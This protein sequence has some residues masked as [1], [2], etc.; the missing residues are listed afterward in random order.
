[1]GK[2]KSA[3]VSF[4]R[5]DEVVARRLIEELRR[6]N[7]AVSDAEGDLKAGADWQKA[8]EH[9]IRAADAVIVLVGRNA[10]PTKYQELEWSTIL[11]SYWDD[12][13]KLLVPV[14][15]GDAKVPSFLAGFQFIRISDENG[16]WGA[17]IA[18]LQD[19]ATE[20]KRSVQKDMTQLQERLKS[21]ENFA[22][23]LKKD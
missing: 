9:A 22:H 16:D 2:V 23:S 14:L 13:T 10:A 8:L 12:P 18:A 1:M 6:H 15:V 3:F 7:F 5:R 19:R 11:E 4:A 17:V 20:E 21:V